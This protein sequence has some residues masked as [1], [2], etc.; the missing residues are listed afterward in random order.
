MQTSKECNENLELGMIFLSKKIFRPECLNR[1]DSA[2]RCGTHHG[3]QIGRTLESTTTQ[4]EC[5]LESGQ[6]PGVVYSRVCLTQVWRTLEYILPGFGVLQST[7]RL[8]QNVLQSPKVAQSPW[9][10]LHRHLFCYKNALYIYNMIHNYMIYHMQPTGLY[11]V[12]IQE[13]LK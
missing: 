6:D 3:L 8:R 1:S 12:R 2:Y 7:P 13:S 5:T 4:A 10:L 9:R 11:I